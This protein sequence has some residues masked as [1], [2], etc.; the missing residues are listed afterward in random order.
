MD[1][2]PPCGSRSRL[3]G[4][5]RSVFKPVTASSAMNSAG[6]GAGAGARAILCRRCSRIHSSCHSPPGSSRADSA[7]AARIPA[8]GSRARRI[9]PAPGGCGYVRH[10]RRPPSA[11][12]ASQTR[13]RPRAPRCPGPACRRQPG[14]RPRVGVRAA[15]SRPCGRRSSR[16]R[17]QPAPGPRGAGRPRDGSRVIRPHADKKKAPSPCGTWRFGL[18]WPLVEPVLVEPAG[19]E[20]ASAS[21][22]RAVLHA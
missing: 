5:S 4:F 18:F 20:P 10:D 19:I 1:S 14:P 3:S 9:C 8:A 22:H 11:R 12:A 17:R 13:R 21:H 6:A 15:P 16:R 7:S 2:K